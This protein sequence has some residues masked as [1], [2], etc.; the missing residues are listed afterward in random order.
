MQGYAYYMGNKVY[1]LKLV[2]VEGL[3]GECLIQLAN[4]SR[5]WVKYECLDQAT[6]QIA[7]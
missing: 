7:S 5:Q 1:I 3:G 2:V 6:W 4:G